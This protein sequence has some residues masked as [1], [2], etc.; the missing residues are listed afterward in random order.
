M[1]KSIG[2]CCLQSTES[3]LGSSSIPGYVDGVKRMFVLE[4]S[5]HSQGACIEGSKGAVLYWATLVEDD[6]G[7]ANVVGLGHMCIL[8][9]GF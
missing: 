9:K 7:P 1:M 8:Q 5:I 4:V 2:K 3:A 6:S